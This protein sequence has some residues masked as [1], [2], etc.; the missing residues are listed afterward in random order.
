MYIDHI[1]KNKAELIILN[2]IKIIDGELYL[3]QDVIDSFPKGMLLEIVKNNIVGLYDINE[4][5]NFNKYLI[6]KKQVFE[7]INDYNTLI[8]R[9][10]R[11]E[12]KLINMKKD[13]F[14]ENYALESYDKPK[15]KTKNLK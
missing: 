7:L 11:L 4:K 1:K 6:D 15:I 13:A 2:K 3:Y 9:R 10:F 14:L 12:K 5:F 8:K